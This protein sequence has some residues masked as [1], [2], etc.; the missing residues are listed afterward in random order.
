MNEEEYLDK[1][2]EDFG[3]IN[4]YS[5]EEKK[6]FATVLK[7]LTAIKD[8]EGSFEEIIKIIIKE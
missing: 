4:H 8:K 2:I 5:S 3:E 1:L 7:K 6:E